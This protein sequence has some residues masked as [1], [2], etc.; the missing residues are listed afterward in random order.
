MAESSERPPPRRRWLAKLERFSGN[1]ITQLSVAAVLIVASVIEAAE[2][3][4]DDFANLRLRVAHGLLI[5]ALW[6]ILRAVPD[7]VEGIE[8]YLES[9]DR[10]QGESPKE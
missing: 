10:R 1:A 7:L 5:V 9:K 6:Q 3:V 8:R 2:T 4:F